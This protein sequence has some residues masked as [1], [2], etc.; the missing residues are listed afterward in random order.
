MASALDL[1]VRLMSP[2]TSKASPE[3]PRP[4]RKSP[5]DRRF[6]MPQEVDK[7]L[8]TVIHVYTTVIHVEAVK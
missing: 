3:E 6:S 1:F 8:T 5:C 7:R 2:S 4:N